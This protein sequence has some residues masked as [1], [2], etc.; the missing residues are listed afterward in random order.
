M[1]SLLVGQSEEEPRGVRPGRVV[2]VLREVE[3]PRGAPVAWE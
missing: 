3:G 2:Y 1:D